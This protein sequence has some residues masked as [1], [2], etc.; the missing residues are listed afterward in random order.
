ML[1]KQ[2]VTHFEEPKRTIKPIEDPYSPHSSKRYYVAEVLKHYKNTESL[3]F[4]HI[5]NSIFFLQLLAK[6]NLP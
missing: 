1:I 3:V 6:Y 5:F 4:E 2:M